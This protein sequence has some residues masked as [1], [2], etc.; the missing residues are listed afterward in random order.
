MLHTVWELLAFEMRPSLLTE[1]SPH[2]RPGTAGG[3]MFLLLAG[4]VAATAGGCK[5]KEPTCQPDAV[6][7]VVH[8][9][10]QGT[11]SQNQDEAGDALP[12]DVRLFE[13]GDGSGLEALDFGLMWENP[14][15]ALGSSMISQDEFTLFPGQTARREIEA[16]PKTTHLLV[17]G[18]FREHIGDT[19]Y[20]VYEMPKYHGHDH[21]AAERKGQTIADPCFQVLV[22]GYQ[23]DGGPT[24]PPG[25][26]LGPFAQTCAP[27][28]SKNPP[29]PPDDGKKKRRKKR[30]LGKKAKDAAKDPPKAPQKPSAPSAPSVP[31]ASVSTWGT[32][33]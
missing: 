19:W 24:S 3:G 30:G 16:N 26:D 32:R 10:I 15:E 4:W 14:G 8:V 7:Y 13:L 27:P 9:L 18:V 29:P 1:T 23:I 11:T 28:P 5:P 17:M 2:R 20:R 22:D 21:C 33:N 31:Q 25:F 6:A 12:L